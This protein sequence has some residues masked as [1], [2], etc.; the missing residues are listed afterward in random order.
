MSKILVV[1][2]EKNIRVTISEFLN[3]AGYAVE[4]VPNG[5]AAL[6]RI[7]AG[8][9]GMVLADVSMPDFSGIELLAQIRKKTERI[10]V[11]MMAGQASIDS[12]VEALR[13]GANDYLTK[14][15]GHET[16]LRSIQQADQIKRLHDEKKDLEKENKAYQ[17]GLE[18][19][20]L[21]RTTALQNAMRGVIS[22]LSSV[23]EARDPYTAGHQRR[24]GN[25]SSAI[26]EKMKLDQEA[27][28]FIRIIGYIHD[29][30]KIVVPAEI[31]SKPGCLSSLE[32]EIIRTHPISGYEMM[33]NVDFPDIVSKAIY[34]H[35]ERCDGSGYP[36][37]IDGHEIVMEAKILMV[38]D[39]VEA[40]VSHRPYRPALGLE[41]ALQEIQFHSETLYDREIVDACVELFCKDH[42]KIDDLEHR[43]RFFV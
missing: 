39:V 13:Y 33:Q 24:V 21:E 3:Q 17:R 8:G 43:I 12:A 37:G 1:D 41:R 16:L 5:G 30:G 25:L 26:A 38:A 20:L 11:I 6:D 28:E 31:L 32:M 34:Q 23:V 18:E 22:L 10:S 9:I 19:I 7:D 2:N 27:I 4:T 42:Y 14:P 40:M 29:I 15:I 36:E 35:H